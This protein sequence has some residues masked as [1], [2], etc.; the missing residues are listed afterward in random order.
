MAM[1]DKIH[2]SHGKT[3]VVVSDEDGQFSTTPVDWPQDHSAE[4]LRAAYRACGADRCPWQLS[5]C[6]GT[7]RRVRDRGRD[8]LG[9]G[10]A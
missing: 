9:G 10:Q 4:P 6:R 5:Q 8:A 3:S 7:V 2:P 1:G